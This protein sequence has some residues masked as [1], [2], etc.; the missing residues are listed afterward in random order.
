MYGLSHMTSS[1]N[2]SYYPEFHAA[3]QSALVKA[4]PSST[5]G[6]C[7]TECEVAGSSWSTNFREPKSWGIWVGMVWGD[8]MGSEVAGT[9][10]DED[11]NSMSVATNK[12]LRIGAH[13]RRNVTIGVSAYWQDWHMS[14]YMIHWGYFLEIDSDVGPL[15]V[16]NGCAESK[17]RKTSAWEEGK[18]EDYL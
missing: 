5:P 2:S 4:L 6:I 16:S 3:A 9:V 1:P 7:S 18:D 14:V 8:C 17:V 13:D 12:L 11:G 10:T 15:Q